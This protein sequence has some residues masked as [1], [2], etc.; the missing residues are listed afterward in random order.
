[1]SDKLINPPQSINSSLLNN[2][3]LMVPAGHLGLLYWNNK[4]LRRIAP[5][6]DQLE[7]AE[8]KLQGLLFYLADQ[9]LRS[10]DLGFQLPDKHKKPHFPLRVRLTVRLVEPET[11]LASSLIEVEKELEGRLTQVL[12][13]E[14]RQWLLHQ[15]Q[16]FQQSATQAIR[17]YPFAELGLALDQAEVEL[18]KLD[19]TFQAELQRLEILLRPQIFRRNFKLPDR[20]GKYQFPLQIRLSY[21]FTS[22][23]QAQQRSRQAV[24]G[25]LSK[26]FEADLRRASLRQPFHEHALFEQAAA[27]EIRSRQFSGISVGNVEVKLDISDTAFEAMLRGLREALLPRSFSGVFVLPER[28]GKHYFPLRVQFDYQGL[29]ESVPLKP[30]F[31]AA[32]SQREILFSPAR[33]P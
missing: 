10:L 17:A 1:V 24:E 16:Q 32:G 27:N 22:V 31:L 29:I 15:H 13:R 21:Q 12:E 26:S 23:E 11:P 28:G 30:Q 6:G 33:D 9:R 5:S 3:R 7:T 20:S 19:E 8:R 14:A 18:D 2:P 25:E 4:L